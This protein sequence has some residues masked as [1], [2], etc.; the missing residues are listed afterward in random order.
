MNLEKVL[1][2]A[3]SPIKV[4]EKQALGIQSTSITKPVLKQ[5]ESVPPFY[6]GMEKQKNMY[7]KTLSSSS[8]PIPRSLS[9]DPMLSSYSLSK[10]FINLTMLSTEL[11][12]SNTSLGSNASRTTSFS[13]IS[14]VINSI[15]KSAAVTK[16]SNGL[17]KDVCDA[18]DTNDVTFIQSLIREKAT[19]KKT[20][21]ELI[22]IRSIEK[23]NTNILDFILNDGLDS[24]IHNNLLYVCIEFKSI[25]CCRLL[26]QH[27]ASPN[28]WRND[29]TP[30]AY[31]VTPLHLASRLGHLSC[32][33]VLH[34]EGN[35]NLNV[36]IDET[37][38][39][40][41]ELSLLHTSVKYNNANVVEYLLRNKA[42]KMG[43][44]KK[45]SASPLH[46]AAEL[47]HY[48]CAKLL[49]DEEVLVDALKCSKRKE[50]ALHLAAQ[51]GY[52]EVASMLIRNSANVNATTGNGETPLHFAAKCLSP[53]VMILLIDHGADV[54]AQDD[55]GRPPLHCVV[56][57]KN[58][59]R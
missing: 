20:I 22:A 58:K 9:T 45:F 24:S 30:T 42:N 21:S 29:P 14:H 2:V 39:D 18:I 16:V 38:K 15:L 41:E 56:L 27:Q 10:D 32:L 48:E 36:G 59:G 57:S 19:D 1:E 33:E 4:Q 44:K 40:G 3:V 12:A 23:H 8:L 37:S 47:N 55:D 53:K 5:S 52:F 7:S 17:N 54:N 13:G 49:L 11:G 35:G 26:L 31:D 6:N 34:K 43:G 28:T 50:T 51:N 46:V 25:E